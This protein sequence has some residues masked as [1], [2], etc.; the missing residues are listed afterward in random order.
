MENAKE[1]SLVEKQEIMERI[2]AKFAS[3]CEEHGLRYTLVGGTLLG[4]VRHQGF[5]PWDD[6]ID[7]GMPRPDY[8][9]F[10]ELSKSGFDG[11]DV[12]VGDYDRDLTVPF[13]KIED[14]NTRIEHD[15]I[16][17]EGEG[18]ALWIDVMP[19]DGLGNDRQKAIELMDVSLKYQTYLGRSASVPFKRRK[20]E[21]GVKGWLRCLFRFGF[22]LAGHERF[23]QKLI[24]LGK[25]HDYDSSDY[26]ACFVSGRYGHGEVLEKSHFDLENRMSF[27][28]HMY[29]AMACYDEYLSGIYGDYMKL[30]PEERRV[31]PHLSH[32][33]MV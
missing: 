4:A 32:A 3:F 2:L 27:C 23:K 10:I 14:R 17:Y 28:G 30:P 11:L 31:S 22:H 13:I 19:Y 7:V 1:L 8:E 25:E 26:V 15:D 18:D 5:I 16:I 21:T 12:L 6:D 9:R 29:R 33:Y 24:S 20:E